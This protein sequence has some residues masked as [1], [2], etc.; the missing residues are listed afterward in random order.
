VRWGSLASSAHTA[1]RALQR[2]E[3]KSSATRSNGP[4]YGPLKVCATVHL[5]MCVCVCVC[6]CG[7]CVHIYVCVRGGGQSVRQS[8]VVVA[9]LCLSW[10]P[11]K[12]KTF[13]RPSLS[14]SLLSSPMYAC[15]CVCVP[16]RRKAARTATASS[17]CAFKGSAAI[18]NI[19]AMIVDVCHVTLAWRGRRTLCS[20]TAPCRYM[21]VWDS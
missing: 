21:Y 2:T 5:C 19:A 10:S 15:V 7:V 18:A 3:A 1:Y 12:N 11:I 8:R 6:V 13:H 17:A 20:D 4:F 9:C 16:M 14:L